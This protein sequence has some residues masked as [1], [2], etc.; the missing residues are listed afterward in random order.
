MAAAE[1]MGER[2][3]E[4]EQQKYNYECSVEALGA[5]ILLKIRLSRLLYDTREF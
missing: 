3:L 4:R 5:G 1:R 2:A